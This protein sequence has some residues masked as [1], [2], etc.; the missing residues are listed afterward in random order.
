MTRLALTTA[1]L[2]A[3]LAMA[4]M[5]DAQS[6]GGSAP[7]G[8]PFSVGVGVGSNGLLVE[9]AVRLSDQLVVRGQGAFMD[10]NYGF[11][12]SGIRYAGRFHFNTGG[13]FLDWHPAANP[14]MITGGGVF[15]E[16]KVNVSAKPALNGTITIHGVVYPVTEVGSVVGKVDYGD[17]APFVGA[18]WD[19]TYYTRR[20]WGFRALAGVAFGQDPPEAQ[21]HAVGP[22][23]TNPSVVSNVQA[24]QATLRH[25]AGDYSYYP[26]VQM[27]V[28]YRF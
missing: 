8:G 28:N 19:N 1:A 14:W 2:L 11:N 18:G 20:G 4:G 23:A 25:D 5:A 26:V 7:G 16:R 21:I 13:A 22:F 3:G 9:G 17:A 15:G 6:Q 10:F 12:S 27:G 24:D